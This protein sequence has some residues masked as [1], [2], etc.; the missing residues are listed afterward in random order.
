MTIFQIQCFL[1]VAEYLNFTEAANHLL[2]SPVF[3]KQ[4]CL[5]PGGRAGYEIICAHKNMS[6]SLPAVPFST[7]NFPN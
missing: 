3:F 6:V 4:K 5:K 2:C 7:K 1:N